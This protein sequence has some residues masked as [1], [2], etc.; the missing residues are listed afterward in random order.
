MKCHILIILFSPKPNPYKKEKKK[1]REPEQKQKKEPEQNKTQLSRSPKREQKQ[2]TQ[3][4]HSPEFPQIHNSWNWKDTQTNPLC[5]SPS[6]SFRSPKLFLK[7]TRPEHQL[8]ITKTSDQKTSWIR[9]P[10]HHQDA[11]VSFL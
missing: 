3:H 4:S 5:S 8:P 1:N 11:V 10:W 9:I 6:D 2:N 7:N